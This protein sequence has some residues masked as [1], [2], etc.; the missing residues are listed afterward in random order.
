MT[1]EA[2]LLCRNIVLFPAKGMIFW[3]LVRSLP[4]ERK[5][6]KA[7]PGMPDQTCG[8]QSEAK[9][10]GNFATN[11]QPSVRISAG[12]LRPSILPQNVRLKPGHFLSGC[13]RLGSRG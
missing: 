9:F 10:L 3:Q 11:T 12:D 2:Q 13:Y 6:K 7:F 1:K 5:P 8:D 4:V